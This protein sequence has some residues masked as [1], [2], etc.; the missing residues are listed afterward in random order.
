MKSVPLD[1]IVAWCDQRLS[2]CQIRDFDGAC[3]GL[4]IANGGR[5]SRIGAAV[6]AGLQ[7]FTD[8][9]AASVD[10]LLVHHGLFWSPLQ[11]ITGRH[12]RKLKVALDGGLAV[13]SAHLPLDAHPQIGNNAQLAAALGLTVEDTFLPYEGT[14]IGLLTGAPPSRDVLVERATAL[15]G[16]RIH[17][18]LYGSS[19]PRRVAILT[20]SGR[21]ALPLLRAH[22]CDTL[23]TGELRQ[24][25]FNLAQEEGFNLLVC[26]HYATEEFGV[27]ALA[28]ELADHFGLPWNFIRQPCTL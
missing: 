28:A 2:V 13:Y 20:G 23:V 12:Y 24:E 4:Q 8:A 5:V 11:P 7:P 27:R 9:V 10:L 26:G 15:F 14:P 1:E 18:I 22:G 6:D 19:H 17:C 25:H 21:S 16:P 3:N